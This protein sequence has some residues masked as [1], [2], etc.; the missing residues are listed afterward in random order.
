VSRFLLHHH[1]AAGECTA[2]FAS[3]RGFSSPL[4]GRPAAC[5]CLFGEHDIWWLVEVD[6][7][8]AAIALLPPFV[9]ERTRVWAVRD[10]SIP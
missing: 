9:A 2:A 6:D 4:R 3:W 1:H 7:Q 5:S 8:D 10:L